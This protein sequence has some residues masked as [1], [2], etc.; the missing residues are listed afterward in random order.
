MPASESVEALAG[1]ASFGLRRE[2]SLGARW[3]YHP[4]T[5]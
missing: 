5:Y 2:R 3:G 4:I 1:R